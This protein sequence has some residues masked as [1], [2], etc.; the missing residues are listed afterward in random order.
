MD[1]GVYINS[2]ESPIKSNSVPIHLKHEKYFQRQKQLDP[3]IPEQ[4]NHP[5][6]IQRPKRCFR[7]L[8]NCV[9]LKFVSCTSNLMGQ[10]R[11]FQ[12]CTM[13][14][15]RSISNLQDLA[16]SESLDTVPVGIVMLYF[17]HD[18]TVCTHLCGECKRSN[19]LDVF[20]K[21]Q[22]TL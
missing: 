17:P 6:S 9:K 10:V 12:I 13:I 2:V 4:A 21:L 19:V 15:L 5:V 20:R 18:S 7:I 14:H 3:I 1:L 11:G 8:L 16:Q 22:S